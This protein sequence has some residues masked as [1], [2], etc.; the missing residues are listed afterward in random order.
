MMKQRVTLLALPLTV[1]LVIGTA[2]WKRPADPSRPA[3]P[4]WTELDTKAVAASIDQQATRDLVHTISLANDVSD[5]LS[6]VTQDLEDRVVRSEL[7]FRQGLRNPITETGVA[8]VV[9]GLADEIN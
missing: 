6:G 5:N 4:A 3:A 9:N 8:N 1:L 7:R 2:A